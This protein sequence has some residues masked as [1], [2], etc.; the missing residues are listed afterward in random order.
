MENKIVLF[1]EENHIPYKMRKDWAN[2]CCPYCSDTNYHLGLSSDGKASCFR[3]GNHNINSVFHELLHCGASEAK[4][5]VHRYVHKGFSRKEEDS[6]LCASA[7][8]FKLPSSGNILKAKIPY[9]YMRRRFPYMSID[10]FV[11][12]LSVNKVTYTD[13]DF[14]MKKPDGNITDKMAGRIV[15]PLIH[16]GKEVSYQCRDYTCNLHSVKYLTAQKEF[17]RVFHKDLLYGE[18]NVPY[19][20][21][22]VCEG[23]FDALSI[24]NGAVHTFGVKWSRSQAEALCAYSHVYIAYDMDKAGEEGAKS[25][26]SAIS[27]RVKVTRVKISEKDIN[28]CSQSEI[29]D[30]KALIM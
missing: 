3:C 29:E 22:I 19:N 6:N 27:H 7:C 21:I 13:T 1:L 15:F 2:I 25:L 4:A 28:S 14:V 17:E 24:G 26:A 20:K 5:L 30:I 8:E 18:D 16:N 10:E 9:V 11:T 12:M 23:V